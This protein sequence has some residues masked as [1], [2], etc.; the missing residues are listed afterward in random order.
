MDICP[1]RRSQSYFTSVTLGQSVSQ[2]V[3][4]Y[5]LVSIPL[6]DLCPDISSCRK[7]AVRKLRSCFCGTPSLTR[8]R[9]CSLQSRRTHNILY[10]LIWDSSNLEG[11]VP[12]FMSHRSRVAQLYHR[13]LGSIYVASY[14]LQS[15]GGGILTLPNVEGQVPVYT[16]WFT[17]F[18]RHLVRAFLR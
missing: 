15:Y 18:S 1:N 16:G 3:S 12:V 13:A 17:K 8:G 4:Q 7:V 5:V 9:V 2:S 14:D 10:C 11:Q 6:W